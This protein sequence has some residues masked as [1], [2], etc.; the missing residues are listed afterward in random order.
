MCSGDAD[1]V[2]YKMIPIHRR[3]GFLPFWTKAATDV[4]HFLGQPLQDTTEFFGR[5]ATRRKVVDILDLMYTLHTRLRLYLIFQLLV[6]CTLLGAGIPITCVACRT[7]GKVPYLGILGRPHHCVVCCVFI[8]VLVA[9]VLA[10]LVVMLGCHAG[11]SNAVR[12]LPAIYQLALRD[13]KLYFNQTVVELFTEL[14]EG[15]RDSSQSVQRFLY[16]VLP[17]DAVQHIKKIVCKGTNDAFTFQLND[18]KH[19]MEYHRVQDIPAE[20]TSG[21]LWEHLQHQLKRAL[22]SVERMERGIERFEAQTGL[23]ATTRVLGLV[24]VPM[25]MVLLCLVVAFMG[26]GIALGIRNRLRQYTNTWFS[27]RYTGILKLTNA[28]LVMMFF[29]F[30]TPLLM[31]MATVGVLGEGYVCKPYR[32]GAYENLHKLIGVVWPYAKRGELFARLTPEH[33]LTKCGGDGVS[34]A[35]LEMHAMRGMELNKPTHKWPVGQSVHRTPQVTLQNATAGNCRPVHDVVRSSMNVFC[36]LYMDNHLGITLSLGTA[37]LLLLLILPLVLAV[38]QYF[39]HEDTDKGDKYQTSSSLFRPDTSE[40]DLVSNRNIQRNH[41]KSRS[42]WGC[43]GS[44]SS[45]H[46][47]FLSDPWKSRLEEIYRM[48]G[49]DIYNELRGKRPALSSK[50]GT[51]SS[52]KLRLKKSSKRAK[53]KTLSESGSATVDIDSRPPRK[54]FV[55][56]VLVDE[57]FP[58]LPS[59]PQGKR[60]K[61]RQHTRRN[62]SGCKIPLV[63]I[64]EESESLQSSYVSA[65]STVSE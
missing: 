65:L 53:E 29:V 3:H 8:G 37:M 31:T 62:K 21:L 51:G 47:S 64:D 60:H 18:C 39:F 41:E 59:V 9:L 55:N 27:L 19:S 12:Q 23:W 20:N 36:N 43:C 4:A 14:D 34:I 6:L 26:F 13:L 49:V 44:G 38:S 16:K 25:V 48:E 11:M 46:P 24:A 35:D 50:S 54:R 1:D 17:H 30:A 28:A 15:D 5:L 63:T 33:I 40:E 10:N 58:R 22:D 57:V 52:L 45:S 2:T 61:F 7:G 42:K 32:T 56:A